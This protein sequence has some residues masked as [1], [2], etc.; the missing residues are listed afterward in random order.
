M[1]EFIVVK[2][3]RAVGTHLI[4]MFSSIQGEGP[5]LGLRQIFLRFSGC[6]LDCAYC[7]TAH[8]AGSVFRVERV[9]GSGNF[10]LYANPITPED[11][12]SIITEF[13]LKYIH[14]LS[15]TGGE[16]LLQT[17]FIK[18]LRPLLDD[19]KLPFYLE[20]NGTLPGKLAE[21]IDYIDIISMDMKLP[22]AG[23]NPAQWEAHREFLKIGVRK[24]IYVKIV[25][26][27]ETTEEEIVQASSIISDINSHIPLILQPVDPLS[28]LPQNIVTVQQ[29]FKFQETSLNYI[30]DVRI[31]P[32]THKV[33]GQL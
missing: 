29:L 14:S 32:Q 23:K 16:P 6:N 26:T 2:W 31:I 17:G 18:K 33:L 25:V 1:N 30:A 28:V 21:V 10:D 9:P 27:G 8:I 20:T 24:N 4:E 22:S 19:Q 5:Y 12:A 7:D 3:G 13:D 15:L 11:T